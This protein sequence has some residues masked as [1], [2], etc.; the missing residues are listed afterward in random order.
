[1]VN[2]A[3][4]YIKQYFF[5]LALAAT[6]I[7]FSAFKSTDHRIADDHWFEVNSAGQIADYLPNGPEANCNLDNPALTMC[8]TRL[9]DAQVDNPNAETPAPT[10]SDPEQG[11]EQK[12]RSE[13]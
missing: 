1:M 11:L 8:A 12:Y 2:K 4:T 3:I 9:S 13:P 10:I 7:G 6:F 5:M